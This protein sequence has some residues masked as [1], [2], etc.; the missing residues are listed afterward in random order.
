M[1]IMKRNSNRKSCDWISAL[2]VL[3]NSRV[4]RDATLAEMEI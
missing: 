1:F 4:G 3:I 2:E